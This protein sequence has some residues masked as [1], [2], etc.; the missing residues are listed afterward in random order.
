MSIGLVGR[1]CGMTRIFTEDGISQPVTVI[2]V[3]PNRVVQVKTKAT[4]GYSAV[5]VTVGTKKRSKVNKAMAGHYAKAGV[6]PGTKVTEFR[7]VDDS[8]LSS[9]AVGSVLTTETFAE[10]QMV[11]VIGTSIGKGYAGVIK[12]YHFA[13]Q[14]ETHGNS[15]TTRAPGSIGQRQSPGKVFKGKRM[16]GHMGNKRKTIL[17]QKIVRIDKERNLIMVRGSVPG[18]PSGEVI[19]RT[20]IKAKAAHKDSRGE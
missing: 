10:G 2:E 6:E 5:Q 12:R 9:L 16:A 17:S 14:D 4:D 1:K 7:V 19:I 11:D 8:A 15:L 3:L 13:S 18:A 20:A